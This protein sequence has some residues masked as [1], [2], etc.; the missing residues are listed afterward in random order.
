[1]IVCVILCTCILQEVNVCTCIHSLFANNV[2]IDSQCMIS[3]QTFGILQYLQVMGH[4][5]VRHVFP[6]Y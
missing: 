1:M 4:D 5:L 3:M 2:E 6:V